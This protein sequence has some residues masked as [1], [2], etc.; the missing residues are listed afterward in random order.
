M[1][2][3]GTGTDRLC[4]KD[5]EYLRALAKKPEITF[6]DK[7]RINEIAEKINDSLR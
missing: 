2:N 6:Y 4:S 3:H 7:S 1:T 5:V